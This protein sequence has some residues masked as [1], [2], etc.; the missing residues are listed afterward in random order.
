MTID[1]KHMK[2]YRVKLLVTQLPI[3]LQ[4]TKLPKQRWIPGTG[5]T[6]SAKKVEKGDLCYARPSVLCSL[7]W[8]TSV[9]RDQLLSQL[10]Q[11][12]KK[13]LCRRMS[14]SCHA[15]Y[16]P[17]LPVDVKIKKKKEKKNETQ[18]YQFPN[19]SSRV[20]R[21]KKI[22]VSTTRRTGSPPDGTHD[23]SVPGARRE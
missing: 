9:E 5:E 18:R 22:Y 19:I 13:D 8:N 21:R 17:I 12:F 11:D 10:L 6:H 20:T 3:T 4:I 7:T 1:M 16:L 14:F 15:K 2:H 23:M